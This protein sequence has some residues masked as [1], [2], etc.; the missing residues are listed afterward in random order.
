[1]TRNINGLIHRQN[2]LEYLL[3]LDEKIDT[4]LISETHISPRSYTKIEG[5]RIYCTP[6]S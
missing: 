2:E 1:M 5:Y 6:E 4:A 3:L